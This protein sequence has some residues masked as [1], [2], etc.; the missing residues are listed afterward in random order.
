MEANIFVNWIKDLN[1]NSSSSE[2][3]KLAK[4]DFLKF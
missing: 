3:F 2:I 4:Y 1:E